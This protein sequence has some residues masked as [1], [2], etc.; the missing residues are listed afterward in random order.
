MLEILSELPGI[1]VNK[2]LQDDG[3]TCS[4]L[5]KWLKNSFPIRYGKF[6]ATHPKK[7]MAVSL[8]FVILCSLGLINFK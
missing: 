6:V 1:K 3:T 8:F 7:V 4:I 2:E 5:S